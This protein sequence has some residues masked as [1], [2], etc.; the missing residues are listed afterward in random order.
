MSGTTE[1]WRAP[2]GVLCV[3][4]VHDETPRY[5]VQIIL[6]GVVIKGDA[7]EHDPDA[8]EFAIAEWRRLHEAVLEP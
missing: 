5:E 3:L 2:N 8:A 4:I 6:N 7:F 1:L